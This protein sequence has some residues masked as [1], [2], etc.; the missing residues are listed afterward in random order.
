MSQDPTPWKAPEKYPDPP[1][2]MWYEVPKTPTHQKLA[3][4]F[5]WE[6]YAD[7]PTRTF[8]EDEPKPQ[9]V[10]SDPADVS[11]SEGDKSSPVTPS[12]PTLASPP[13]DPWQSYSRGN[14]WDNIPEIEQYIGKLQK[15]RKGNI[16]VL[17]GYGAGNTNTTSPKGR[18]A[19]IKL[20]DF[21][22]EVE[23][24][25]LPVTPAPIRRPSFW[26]EERDAEGDLP[27]AVGVPSQEEWVLLSLLSRE[28]S[29]L[30]FFLGSGG[31]AGTVGTPSIRGVGEKA[32]RW[33]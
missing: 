27:P 3:P 14:A 25:S 21:P 24:P 17:Q 20:T 11:P 26:G 13:S 6:K 23:R 18:R 12:T 32:G 7:P 33:Q 10:A 19:S 9:E 5:P 22:T 29:F 4:I 15:N 8:L 2:D 28:I 30:L 16:Q 1:K 31:E